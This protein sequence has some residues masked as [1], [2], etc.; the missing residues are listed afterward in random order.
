MPR[1]NSLE[2]RLHIADFARS[3]AFYRDVVG[4]EVLALFPEDNPSFALM[5]RDGV[6]LQIGGVD[7]AKTDGAAPS[8]TLYFDVADANGVHAQLKDRVKIEWGPEVYFYHRRE[9]AFHDPDGHLIIISE[10]TD[11]PVTAAEA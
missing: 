4:F 8:V 1:F 2:P 11:D 7:A 6:G 10:E 3:L 5:A 9:F